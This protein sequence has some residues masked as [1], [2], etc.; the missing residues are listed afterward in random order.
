MHTKEKIIQKATQLFAHSGYEVLSMRTLAQSIPI[1]PSV[2]YHHFKD[3]DV[4]LKAMFD[5]VNRQLGIQRKKLPTVTT[6]SEMLFQRIIFQLDHAEE[7]VA[8]LKYYITYRKKFKKNPTGF[9]PE[10]TA[11]HIEEV[12]RF[13]IE[14]DEFMVRDVVND[15]KIITHAINGFLLE[16]FPAKLTKT[17]KKS[18]AVPLHAFL[19]RALRKE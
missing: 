12:L 17:E 5:H 3:K 8:V 4:L 18:I 14:T 6:A 13:G 10:K 11:L 1:T 15:A 16:Y 19:L 7:I 2:L 9:V